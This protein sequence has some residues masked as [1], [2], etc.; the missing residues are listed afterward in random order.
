MSEKK[1]LAMS[2][3]KT[4]TMRARRNS[5]SGDWSEKRSRSS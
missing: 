4:L 3:K 2:E 5:E 1:T